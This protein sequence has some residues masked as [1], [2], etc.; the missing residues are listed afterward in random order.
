MTCEEARAQIQLY[1][2]HEMPATETMALEAHLVD[3]ERCRA[4]YEALLSV[5]DAVRGT[6]PLYE[7]PKE[8][9]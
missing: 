8:S 4:E 5:V 6:R 7:A 3:C 9:V 2:D 1:V